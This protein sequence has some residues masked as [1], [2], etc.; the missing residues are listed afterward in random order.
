MQW[1]NEISRELKLRYMNYYKVLLIILIASEWVGSAL[2]T[3]E[4]M[5]CFAFIF[6]FTKRQASTGRKTLASRKESVAVSL[7]WLELFQFHGNSLLLRGS[8]LKF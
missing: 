4:S 2:I 8:Y 3:L 6:F 5:F 7:L 1:N